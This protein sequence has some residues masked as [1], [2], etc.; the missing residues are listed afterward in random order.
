MFSF[1][2]ELSPS[3]APAEFGLLLA[4]TA[5]VVSARLNLSYGTI[6][7]RGVCNFLGS[8]SSQQKIGATDVKALS[9]S[10]LLDRLRLSSWTDQCY[11]S[12]LE[13]SFI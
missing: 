3:W 12:M 9:M 1:Y 7:V 6:D 13:L 4:G 2:R 5:E 11:N 10:Q 8:V